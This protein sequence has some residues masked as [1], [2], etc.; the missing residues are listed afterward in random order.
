MY[1][2]AEHLSKSGKFLAGHSKMREYVEE[3]DVE[4]PSKEKVDEFEKVLSD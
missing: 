2:V 3:V 1:R 4:Q